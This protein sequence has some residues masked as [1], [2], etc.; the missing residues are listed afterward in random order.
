MVD[1]NVERERV[2][3]EQ[4][5]VEVERVSLPTAASSRTPR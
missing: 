3:V 5:R 2:N 1:V 4:A